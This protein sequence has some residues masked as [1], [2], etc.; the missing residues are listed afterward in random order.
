MRPF[1]NRLFLVR[2]WRQNRILFFIS[3]LFISAAIYGHRTGCEITP[4][5]DFA[6]YSSVHRSKQD[7]FLLVQ[8][9]GKTLDLY[10]TL[11]EPRRMMI[12]STLMAYH[13]GVLNG[14]RDPAE[15]LVTAVVAKH[16]FMRPL[17]G[18]AFCK[19]GDYKGY[20]PW[21]GRYLRH[22][23]DENADTFRVSL[24]SLHYNDRNLPVTD[25]IKPLYTFEPAAIK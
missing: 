12:F 5:L 4:A 8:V 16:P 25:S 3:L 20:L 10:H 22:A 24:L 17:S 23:V 1:F 14:H 9:H 19:P 7:S 2:C 11:D 21:L 6:M 13:R 15:D 18:R